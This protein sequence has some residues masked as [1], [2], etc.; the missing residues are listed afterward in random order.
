MVA[1]RMHPSLL[2]LTDTDGVAGP[3]ALEGLGDQRFAPHGVPSQCFAS[4]VPANLASISRDSN[5]T[6]LR[7]R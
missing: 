7:G 1:I 2:R 3:R 4:G 5:N 6:E